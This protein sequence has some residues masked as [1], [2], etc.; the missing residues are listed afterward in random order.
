M[1]IPAEIRIKATIQRGAV[2][3][4]SNESPQFKSD[5]PHYYIVLNKNPLT[6]QI[7]YLVCASSQLEKA[8]ERVATRK[9]PESTLVFVSPEEY[10]HFS[11]ETVISCNSVFDYDLQVLTQK[12]DEKKL[13]VCAPLP[14]DT[15]KSLIAG[16]LDSPMVQRKIKRQLQN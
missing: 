9:F 1:E 12:L 13:R 14:D 3:Y 11:K 2:Y 16:V 5:E 4:F 10:A 6:E 15:V 8:K 7:L